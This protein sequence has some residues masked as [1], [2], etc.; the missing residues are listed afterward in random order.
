MPEYLKS[1]LSTLTKEQAQEVWDWADSEP[2]AEDIINVVAPMAG[3]IAEV[4][5]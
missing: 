5:E 1:F 3:G 2:A 4:K